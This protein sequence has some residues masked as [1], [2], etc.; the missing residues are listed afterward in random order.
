MENPELFIELKLD[1]HRA[2]KNTSLGQDLFNKRKFKESLEFF[3]NLLK[4]SEFFKK[5]SYV[6]N[7]LLTFGL[8]APLTPFL[9][10]EKLDPIY[11][12]IAYSSYW[13]RDYEKSAK[14]F[15]KIYDKSS[16]DIYMM[17]WTYHNL[18]NKSFSESLFQ[19]SFKMDPRFK[20]L[21]CPY[22]ST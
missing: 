7:G 19:R 6:V 15:D 18:K 13:L 1:H 4:E 5:S 3:E 20:E 21:W 16:Y 14:Y 2:Y 22:S 8:A 12:G 9:I 10:R 11:K 17:A